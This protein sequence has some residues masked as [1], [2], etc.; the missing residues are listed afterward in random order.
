MKS[1]APSRRRHSAFRTPRSALASRPRRPLFE[2]LENRS[3]LAGIAPPD[4]LVA[5]WPGESTAADIAGGNNGTLLLG[6]AFAAGQ[7]DQSFRFDGSDARVE[8]G[9]VPSLKLTGSITIEAWVNVQSLPVGKPHGHILFRGDDRNGLDPYYLSVTSDGQFRFNIDSLTAKSQ[10]QGGA[11]PLGQFV[12]VAATLDDATGLQRIYVNGVVAAETTT[13]VRPFGD[14]DP[15]SNPGIAI[16]NHSGY[17]TSPHNYPLNGRIDELSVYS[18]ALTEEEVQSIY[19]AGLAGDG[20]ISI[21]ISDA[22]ADEGDSSSP[23][24]RQVFVEKGSGG[25][26]R[27]RTLTFRD[28]YLIVPDENGDAVRRYNATTGA[29]IDDFIGSDP[30]LNGG[31]DRPHAAAFGPGGDLFV[32]SF[33][34]EEILRYDGD[35]GSFEGVFVSAGSGGLDLPQDLA[36]DNAGNLYVTTDLTHQVM[37]YDT[38]GNPFPSAS[39]AAGTAE[40]VPTGSGGLLHGRGLIF[41]LSGNLYVASIGNDRVLKYSGATGSS[42]GAF[43]A[44][45]SGGLDQP[46]S[47][48]FGPD[49]NLYVGSSNLDAVFRYSGT[50]GQFIDTFI[51]SGSGSLDNPIGIAFDSSGRF[52]VASGQTGQVLQYST[53][54]EAIFTVSISSPS[55]FAV[56]VNYST[57][58]DSASAGSDFTSASGMITFAPGQTSRTILVPTNDDLATESN[59]TFTVVLSAAQGGVII[60]DTGVGTIIDNDTKFYVVDDAA[61]NRTFEYN[62]SGSALENYA[63]TSGNSAPRG[64]AS[65]AATNSN[66]WVVDANK[67]VYVYNT[68]GGLLGSWTAGSLPKNANV[69]GITT[70]GTDVWIVDAQGDKV[71]RYANAANRLSGSQNAA[72]SFALNSGNKDASDLVTDGASIWVLN[73]TSTDK[74]FKYTVSGTLQGSWTITGGGGSPTGLTIDPSG[75]STSIWIVDNTSDRV[76]EFTNA[77][78]RTSASQSPS[79][80]FPLSST[81]TNPQGIA[82]PPVSLPLPTLTRRVSEAPLSHSALRVP[83][84]ALAHDSA[85]LAITGELS[86]LL[87]LKKRR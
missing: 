60:D 39:G 48:T 35:D 10:I 75:V 32:I 68:S 55:S 82:D 41:D 30:Q 9:D 36:F 40:F 33:N 52:Y 44:P 47:L 57:A 59:E 3:L 78:A 11:V 12:H 53:E 7:V 24:F 5:W 77:R 70:N 66:V 13:T 76:Y 81:N 31:L 83:H 43:V 61:T 56:T 74:V 17:P 86:S 4:G 21:S 38:S 54:S 79:T 14:L 1:A 62:A 87:N 45:G 51:A 27:P 58:S 28:G 69:Q 6:A 67:N 72:S 25:L 84:S 42:L 8:I 34:T 73:N 46:H 85:L 64:A 65:T 15:T 19:T 26:R 50:S 63:V 29:F 2:T 22:T 80:S 16:G 23:H 71:Y 20:K 49:G 37:R 18:R